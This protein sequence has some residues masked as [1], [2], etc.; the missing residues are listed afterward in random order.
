MLV[1]PE[2]SG[3]TDQIRGVARRLANEGYSALVFDLYSRQP[4]APVGAE[5]DVVVKSYLKITDRMAIMDM[6]A[7]MAFFRGL[8]IVD[9]ERIG[10]IGFCSA[11]PI[12]LACHDPRIAACV[13][14]YNQIRYAEGV[15]AELAVHPIDRV[16]NLWC[17][18]QG[19]YGDNDI[20]VS[21]SDIRDMEARLGEFQIPYELYTYP[22]AP[23]GFFNEQRPEHD[24]LAAETAWP[25]VT[26]FLR[27]NLGA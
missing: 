13:S 25:R 22:G 21:M 11:Y 20:A 26:R 1:H 6:D 3:L 7:A 5:F 8:S 24:R 2:A 17:P 15:N 4:E 19:H 23:H 18:W 10:V 14:F 9:P 12:I 27:E 16:A